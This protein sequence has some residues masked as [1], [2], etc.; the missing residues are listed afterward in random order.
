MSIE[1]TLEDLHVEPKNVEV[2]VRIRPSNNESEER[3]RSDA[4]CHQTVEILD[5]GVRVKVSSST[6]KS[7]LFDGTFDRVRYCIT[8]IKYRC[9]RVPL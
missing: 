3:I 1:T 2:Y 6:D 4:S 5:D 8:K 9:Q 7:T